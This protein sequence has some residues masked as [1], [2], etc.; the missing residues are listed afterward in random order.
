MTQPGAINH[1]E[2]IQIA[3]KIHYILTAG[4]TR[5]IFHTNSFLQTMH[6][7]YSQEDIQNPISKAELSSSYKL[8][9]KY[10]RP[11]MYNVRY[12]IIL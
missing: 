11:K 8:R 10:I 4:N 2:I 12:D 6:Y 1:A 7:K 9:R 3:K 5:L